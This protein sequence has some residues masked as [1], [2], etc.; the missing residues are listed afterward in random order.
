MATVELERQEAPA[1]TSLRPGVPG[2]AKDYSGLLIIGLALFIAIYYYGDNR[3]YLTILA[4][5]EASIITATG[6]NL[7]AGYT[8]QVSL[9]HAGFFALGGYMTGLLVGRVATTINANGE[10]WIDYLY[11]RGKNLTP[12]DRAERDVVLNSFN[13]ALLIALPILLIL[14]VGIGGFL[15]LRYQNAKKQPAHLH[16]SFWSNPYSLFRL[17]ASLVS[18]GVLL[19]ILN[20]IGL[21][22]GFWIFQNLWAAIILGGTVAAVFGYALSLPALRVKGPYLAMVTIAFGIIITEVSNSKTLEPILGGPS[23]LQRI[24]FPISER[25]PDNDLLLQ[26]GSDTGA[27]FQ[28]FQTNLILL[29]G[30]AV[31]LYLVRNFVRSRWGRSFIALRENEIGAA[32]VGINVYRM[33]T[34]AFVMSATLTGIG[35]ALNAYS[36]GAVNPQSALLD[37]SISFVTMIILGGIGTLYGPAL[38]A[39]I[40]TLLPEFLNTLGKTNHSELLNAG[41]YIWIILFVAAIAGAILLPHR[42]KR[43]S[44]VFAGV[45]F[46]YNIPEIYR[47]LSGLTK[48]LNPNSPEVNYGSDFSPTIILPSLYGAIL[49]FFLFLAPEGLGGYIG[50]FINWL[51]PTKSKITSASVV[52][53]S[54]DVG[55][56]VAALPFQCIRPDHSDILKTVSITRDFKGLRAVDSVEF[57]LKRGEIHALIGP[58]GAGKTTVLNLISG[59]YPV[60]QGQILFKGEQIDGLKPHEIA[61]LGISRTFQNL[62]V[63]GDMT[64]LEN[65]MV[66]FHLSTRQGFWS[67]LLGLPKVKAEDN[68]IR[69]QAMQLLEFVGLANRAQ[70]RAK[71]L[72]YGYQR[73]L[74]IAR[75]LAV[76][77][78]ILLLDE[79]AAGLNPQEIGDMDSL[80]RKIQAE[81]VTVL[82]I[83]HHM[84]LVM[85]IS[86]EITVL[87][88]GKKIAEGNPSYVQNNQKV[89]DAYFGPEVMLDARS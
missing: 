72:P 34:L 57:N 85:E 49:L 48:P 2:W 24:P 25:N 26:P 53:T 14:T 32:S 56:P 41:D 6:L 11:V 1:K 16:Y 18:I 17:F 60:S 8:G 79:P 46:L 71:D 10:N 23:G 47:I 20:I 29:V 86:D 84:D 42:Y 88:Y 35:G 83:E 36:Y 74:E 66:G 81:G 69:A 4:S 27:T 80:I 89:K 63:F 64:V 68:R 33:K 31:A 58:N 40:I 28:L 5:I 52:G 19:L 21:T 9:G 59:L 67:S 73:L 70:A 13:T 61:K 82:L 50:R 43:L 37:R 22:V 77:P 87:D 62:Q 54:A 30:V 75:A 39:I 7:V 76:K 55:V 12:S 51:L 3:Y 38:G 78:E 45:I 15:W 65:V 44:G